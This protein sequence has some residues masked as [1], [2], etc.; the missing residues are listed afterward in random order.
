MGG[1][2]KEAQREEKDIGRYDERCRL[3]VVP[4]P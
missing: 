4:L 2:E 3:E 1:G